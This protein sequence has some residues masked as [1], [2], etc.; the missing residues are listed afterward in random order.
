LMREVLL[1]VGMYVIVAG[2][3]YVHDELEKMRK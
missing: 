2:A 3:K 1:L